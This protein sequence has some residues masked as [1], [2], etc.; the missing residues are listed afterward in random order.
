MDSKVTRIGRSKQATMK[1]SSS[2]SSLL[3]ASPTLPLP[4]TLLPARMK[5]S[6][7]TNSR[8]SGAAAAAASSSSRAASDMRKRP[9][10]RRSLTA[11]PS[12]LRRSVSEPP[13]RNAFSGSVILVGPIHNC[14]VLAA[15]IEKHGGI[16]Q[17][18]SK[19]QRRV[20]AGAKTPPKQLPRPRWDW[21]VHHTE[22]NISLPSPTHSLL[23][24]SHSAAAAA[25]G[26]GGGQGCF[27]SHSQKRKRLAK[28]RMGCH[29]TRGLQPHSHCRVD[30]RLC[31]EQPHRHWA[32]LGTSPTALAHAHRVCQRPSSSCYGITSTTTTTTTT[33]DSRPA[34]GS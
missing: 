7:S 13:R 32:H 3:G 14:K 30:H 26:T 10:L 24:H 23:S 25:A 17:R 34:C 21:M 12:R 15:V 22:L 16:V 19:Q 11:D 29:G 31:Q 8:A 1:P 27:T 5:R 6:N 4:P 33:C 9:R 2:S 18:P 28:H 20:V